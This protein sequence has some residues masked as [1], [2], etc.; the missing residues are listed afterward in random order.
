MPAEVQ[1]LAG[2]A[3][4]GKTQRLLNHYRRTLLGKPNSTDATAI[5][6]CCWLAPNRVALTQIQDQLLKNS[7]QAFLAPNLYTFSA[8]A[9]SLITRSQRRIR[10]VARLQ[11]RRLLQHVIRETLEQGAINHFA[12]VAHTP[13]FAIQVDEFIAE[14][15]RADVW[16][17]L[18]QRWAAQRED[19][20]PLEMATL[21][22]AYQRALHRGELYDAEGR[23]WAAREILDN[24]P[25]ASRQEYDLLIVHGFNDFTTAQYDILRLLSQRCAQLIISL[26][27]EPPNPDPTNHID[28]GRSLLFAKTN[29]TL[30]RLQQIFPQLQVHR[31]PS[32]SPATHS[33]QQFQQQLFCESQEESQESAEKFD[34]LEI[35]AANSALGEVEAIAERIKTLL[36]TDQARP[37]DILLVSRADEL[38]ARMI[39]EVFDDYGIPTALESQPRLEAEPLTRALLSLLRLHQ[40]DWPF[41]TLLEVINNRLFT[42]FDTQFDAQADAATSFATQPRVALEHCLRSAQLPSGKEALLEQLE[43]RQNAATQSPPDLQATQVSVALRELQQL[44]QLLSQ[45]PEKASINDWTQHLEQLL[46]QLGVLAV[47]TTNSSRETLAWNL[48]RRGLQSLA[49]VDTWSFTEDRSLPLPKLIELIALVAREQRLPA[50]QDATGCVRILSAESARKLTVKHL[51]LAGLSEQ[52]FS[53]STTTGETA[54]ANQ[55]QALLDSLPETLVKSTTVDVRQS[56]SMLLFYELVTRATQSLTLSYAALDAKGQPLSPSPLLTEMVRCAGVDRITHHTMPL[57]QIATLDSLPHSRST[58][59]RQAVDQALQGKPRWLAGMISQAEFVRTGSSILTGIDCIAQRGQRDTFG[60][61]EGLVLSPPAQAALAQRFDGEHNWSPS[62]LEG[63]ATCPFRFFAEQLLDLEP[64]AELTLRNDPRRRGNLLHQVLATIHQQ[65]SQA[66]DAAEASDATDAQLIEH[67]LAALNAAIE[68]TPLRGLQQA[69]R[70][71]ERREIE[72]WAPDYAQQETS[73]RSQ[74]NQFDEPPRPAHFEVRFGPSRRSDTPSDQAS[75]PVPFELDLGDERI[76]LTGQIDRIDIGRIG[77]LTVFNIIDY[78]SGKAVKLQLDKVRSGHQ[79]QLPLYALA[80]E[81]LLLADQQAVALATGYWN[82]QGKGFEKGSSGSLH[83]RE[84]AGEDLQTSADWQQLQPTML[85]RVQ[86]LITG[87]RSGQFPV[88]NADKDCTR[89]CSLSTIC[90]IAHIRSLEKVPQPPSQANPDRKGAGE[91][92]P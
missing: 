26:T 92:N 33:L 13:G 53:S 30:A 64:L 42:R 10:P 25:S 36:V 45:L 78:K 48:L 88:Y 43:Y 59:R 91:N 24:Q 18:F 21:Y 81:Q 23:F 3:R 61:Y 58:F 51:F 70:E 55:S 41:P 4:C 89:S 82:I 32:P 60:P 8:F 68:A 67:F 22:T 72:A 39:A 85:R 79:L 29:Q 12:Q 52:S 1:L 20:Q 63:Y 40:E 50:T 69:L 17:D 87:I 76:R 73:Y 74:W 14:L 62:Q 65:L 84:L 28:E 44:A 66:A 77:G 16:P 54:I 6:R 71:I 35:L 75:T 57:G 38:S 90:R 56:N 31:E 86:E 15:K 2:P 49:Q 27:V 9:D 11:K 46:T 19:R 37:Q 47:N 34:G 80:A 5:D 83:L 7:A